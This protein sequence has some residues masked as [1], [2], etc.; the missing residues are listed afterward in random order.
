MR[1]CETC[2]QSPAWPGFLQCLSCIRYRRKP[3]DTV[4]KMAESIGLLQAKREQW[5]GQHPGWRLVLMREWQRYEPPSRSRLMGR[6]LY[7]SEYYV[8]RS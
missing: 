2:D 5:E 3:A 4:T 7:H 1:P 6:R 8:S